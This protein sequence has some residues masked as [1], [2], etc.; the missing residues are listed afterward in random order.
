MGKILDR[1]GNGVSS[2]LV[3]RV[4]HQITI[5]HK[6]RQF[7]LR[8]DTTKSFNAWLKAFNSLNIDIAYNEPLES[9]TNHSNEEEIKNKEMSVENQDKQMNVDENEENVNN[10]NYDEEDERLLAESQ[11]LEQL[12]KKDQK[13]ILKSFQD[14]RK[15]IAK[16]DS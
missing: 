14:I 8:M 12:L 13:N 7:A 2:F 6:N 10:I 3:D 9:K 4:N 11:R 1:N 5:S 16:T 15:S